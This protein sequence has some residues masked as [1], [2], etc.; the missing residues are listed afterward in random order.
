MGK[1][2]G[3]PRKTTAGA[4]R[5]RPTKNQL[6]VE[7]FDEEVSFHFTD[8]Q[9]KRLLTDTAKKAATETVTMINNTRSSSKN[10]ASQSESDSENSE[11]ESGDKPVIHATGNLPLDLHVT[12]RI[13]S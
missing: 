4:K 12:P 7:E 11:N 5:G 8:S 2:R 10:N 3:S 1:R 13:G 9:L 6:T